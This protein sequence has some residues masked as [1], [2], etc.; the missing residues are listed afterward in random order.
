MKLV[1]WEDYKSTDKPF[2][3]GEICVKTETMFAGY[4]GEA[5]LTQGAVKDGWFHT[6]DIGRLEKLRDGTI[7][8][9][10]LDRKKNLFKLAQGEFVSPERLE[11]KLVDCS[12]VEQCFIY[13]D[14]LKT[15]IVAV[16]KPDEGALRKWA[17]DNGAE[18]KSDSM[19]AL[20]ALSEVQ[21]Q[22]LRSLCEHGLKSQV[23]NLTQLC[24]ISFYW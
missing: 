13:G 15:I 3:R 7:R 10:L 23:R 8:V 14:G 12:F 5:E 20:Y 2:P 24:Y 17:K 21:E 22:V 4:Y 19:S 16:V 9:V 18:L 6:G 1:D 11:G